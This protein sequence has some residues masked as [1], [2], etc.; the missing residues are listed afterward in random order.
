MLRYYFIGINIL[1]F[2]FFGIDKFAAILK[3]RRI[4]ESVLLR[5]SLFGG[6]YGSILGMILFHHK[7]RKKIFIRT[8]IICFIVY[9]I[10]IYSMWRYLWN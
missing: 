4:P 3:F 1:S 6:V 2:V 5:I 10:F 8:N 7:I 9:T